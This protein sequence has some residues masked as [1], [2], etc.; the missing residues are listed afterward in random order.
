MF[1]LINLYGIIAWLGTMFQPILRVIF[2][3]MD[4]PYLGQ[5][6]C[7]LSFELERSPLNVD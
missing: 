7:Y 6:L 5:G 2:K 4:N 1:T 3:D